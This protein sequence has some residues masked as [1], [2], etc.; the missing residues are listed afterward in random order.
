MLP[1]SQPACF[2]VAGETR[3]SLSEPEQRSQVIDRTIL[4]PGWLQTSLSHQAGVDSTLYGYSTANQDLKGVRGTFVFASDTNIV[5]G[6]GTNQAYMD[7]RPTRICLYVL[8][9][10][11]GRVP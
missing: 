9:D 10:E 5:W 4:N 2:G 7:A 3:Q 8:L 6:R 11:S 1:L